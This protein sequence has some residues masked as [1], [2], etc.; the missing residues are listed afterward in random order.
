MGKN[1]LEQSGLK[2]FLNILRTVQR[3]VE[4][5]EPEMDRNNRANLQNS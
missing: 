4:P 3:V 1:E 5:N 2:G